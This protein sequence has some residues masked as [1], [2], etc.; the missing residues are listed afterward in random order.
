VGGVGWGGVSSG[1]RGEGGEEVLVALGGS[2]RRGGS[3]DGGGGGCGSSELYQIRLTFERQLILFLLK[4]LEEFVDVAS[5]SEILLNVDLG[6]QIIIG[7]VLTVGNHVQD[8][9]HLSG[10]L[11]GD[12]VWQGVYVGEVGEV[13][14]KVRDAGETSCVHVLPHLPPT[15]SEKRVKVGIHKFYKTSLCYLL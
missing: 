12:L 5:M 4:E 1:G 6:I 7:R 8:R 15:A 3:G 14:T 10:C 2:E 9:L 11:L 13:G